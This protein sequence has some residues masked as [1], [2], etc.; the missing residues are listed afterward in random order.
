MS[1]DEPKI[2]NLMDALKAG[3]A[4][5]DAKRE[6]ADL[7]AYR[8][9]TEAGLAELCEKVDMLAKLFGNSQMRD[10]AELIRMHGLW[11]NPKPEAKE[12]P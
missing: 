1:Y 4:E 11:R 5:A 3:V 2:L 8:E 9:R 6:L 12:Q 7:R 10:V